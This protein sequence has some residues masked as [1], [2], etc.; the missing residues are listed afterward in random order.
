MDDILVYSPTLDQHTNHLKA[1]FEILQQH[2]LLL[3]RSKCSFAQEQLEYLGHI[4]S[5]SGVSTDPSK[6]QA[7]QD[8][9]PPT[10]VKQV[11]QFLGLAGYYRKFIKNYGLISRTLTDLLKKHTQ[12]QWTPQLQQCFEALKKALISAPVLSLADFSKEFTIET[13]ASDKGIGAVLMQQ[14]HPIAY[15]SKALSK[16]SQALSTY[17][18]CLAIILAVDKWRPYLQHQSIYNC[19]RPE[20]LG[21][22]R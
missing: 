4:I 13:D 16:R 12:F 7:V 22:P 21:T 18:E 15:L 10:H 14:G 8:W 1:V 5:A 9:P 6:I 20:K 19:H 17:E 3:K 2:Q 11:R